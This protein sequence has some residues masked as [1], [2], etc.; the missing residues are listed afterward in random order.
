M[1][2]IIENFRLESL[3]D[4]KFIKTACARYKHNGKEKRWEILEAHNSV[5]ALL[6]H[7]KKDSFILVKQF[8]P[9]VYRNNKDGMVLELCAG[10]IDKNIPDINIMQEEIEEECGYSVSIDKIEKIISFY[11]AVGFS[12]NSQI[13]YYSEINESMKISEG[14]GLS[15]ENIEVIE[16]SV[17]DAYKFIF[18]EFIP[19]TPALIFA[20]MWWFQ[21]FK[22]NV[23]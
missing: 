13:L 2:N 16:L 17:K 14:G 10:I 19:K 22:F 5:M 3:R 23:L 7:K 9:A 4:P 8:R 21:K 15:E 12:G 1:K 6:Y 20:I 18:D 11:S